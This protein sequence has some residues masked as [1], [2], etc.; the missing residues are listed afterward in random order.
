MGIFRAHVNL[1]DGPYCVPQAECFSWEEYAPLIFHDFNWMDICNLITSWKP[2]I[3]R[4]L[5]TH[6]V[7]D[8]NAIQKTKIPMIF[9]LL[10]FTFFSQTYVFQCSVA[11]FLVAWIRYFIVFRKARN[12]NLLEG[13]NDENMA[14]VLGIWNCLEIFSILPNSN[15]NW[16]VY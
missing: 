1:A 6:C 16:E 4:F 13:K 8:N 5:P 15:C 12:T 11:F 3:C 10:F 7:L 14:T 9:L 2:L